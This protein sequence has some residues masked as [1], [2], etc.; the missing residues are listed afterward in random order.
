MN[1]REAI[2]NKIHILQCYCSSVAAFHQKTQKTHYF[3][4][5]NRII[6]L[7]NKKW[8]L[9]TKTPLLMHGRS[10]RQVNG[11]IWKMKWFTWRHKK[12]TNFCGLNVCISHYCYN[13][14]LWANLHSAPGP[15]YYCRYQSVSLYVTILLINM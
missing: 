8:D 4:E 15:N 9:K 10:F 11:N 7:S 14:L 2:Q 1:L 3:K 13:L 6:C 12:Q 5:K